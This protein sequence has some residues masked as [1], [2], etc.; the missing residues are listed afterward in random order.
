MKLKSYFPND[1]RNLLQMTEFQF[2]HL[3]QHVKN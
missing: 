2:E 1:Y 3:F